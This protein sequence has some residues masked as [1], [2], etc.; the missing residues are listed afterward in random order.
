MST[1][2]AEPGYRWVILAAATVILALVMG[3]IIN[4]L[5][6]Y[7]VPL[8][9][10]QG[11][12]RADVAMINSM[13]L[14]GLA[15]GSL[16]A[17][18]A[19][20]RFGVRPVV[21]VGVLAAGFGWML[22]SRATS[23]GQFYAASFFVGAIGGG[24][25]AGPIMALVGSWFTKGAGLALG[26]AAAG[27]ATGQGGMPF[28]GA[29]LIDAAGWRTSLAMQG[30]A[31]L[32]LLVPLALLLKKP[33]PGPTGS[34]MSRET[35]SGLPN[36]LVTAWVA[37]AALFC[38][39]CMA[40]PLMHL[41]PLIQGNGI[42]APEAG[43]V[44]FTMMMVAIVGRIAFGKLAD[45]IGAIPTYL[46]ASGWQTVLVLGFVFLNKLEH[47]YIYAMVF[48]FGYAGVMTSIFVTVRTL[49]APAFR[50]SS[51]GIVLTFAY[52]GHGI[53]G[54]QGGMFYDLTGTYD[55]T[56]RN[57]ALAGLV[58]LTIL[59]ALWMTLR[60]PPRPAEPLSV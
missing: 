44:L 39:T 51:M 30:L 15:I 1:Q 52:I 6:V 37:S 28:A 46:I 11:W 49:T 31:T 19:A 45:T 16:V 53:G 55:W 32:V 47:F 48:G 59:S 60:R 54:W 27:Q 33:P 12:S 22:A 58:N 42:T 2:S 41:V 57:A 40:V 26:I 34:A 3:Q 21:L 56:Y 5:S 10:E 8:E 29:F 36:W 14:L 17:G 50:A 18:F 35:P 13:G 43:S 4:G 7:F 20:D 24:T 9:A 23:L 25:I 38:C